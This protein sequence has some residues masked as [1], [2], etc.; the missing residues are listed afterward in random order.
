MSKVITLKEAYKEALHSRVFIALWLVIVLQVVIF[1][2]ML[3]TIGRI[4]APNAPIRCDGFQA[5]HC[6]DGGIVVANGSYLVNFAILAII[7]PI[8]NVFTSLKLYA[9]KGR[10]IG[11][12]VLWLTIVIFIIATVFVAALLGIGNIR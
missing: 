3:F 2:V 6:V 11:L 10:Q 5:T 1:L 9:Y 7:V 4:E 12:A 8:I